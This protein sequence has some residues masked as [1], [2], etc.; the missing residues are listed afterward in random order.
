MIKLSIVYIICR[1]LFGKG[2]SKHGKGQFDW[3]LPKGALQ[4]M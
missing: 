2:Q 4:I 1:A 3:L